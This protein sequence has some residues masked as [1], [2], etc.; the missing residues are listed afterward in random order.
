MCGARDR[1]AARAGCPLDDLERPF[2]SNHCRTLY[3]E[4][5]AICLPPR[6]A[7][8]LH[9]TSPIRHLPPPPHSFALSLALASPTPVPLFLPSS[10]T[11]NCALWSTKVPNNTSKLER[12]SLTPARRRRNYDSKA[13]LSHASRRRAVGMPDGATAHNSPLPLL[14]E[15]EDANPPARH[16]HTAVFLSVGQT[17]SGSQTVNTN[18]SSRDVKDTDEWRVNVVIQGLDLARGTICGSME[19]LDVPKAVSP[20]VT[21]WKGEIIDNRNYFFWTGR[22]D[23]EVEQDV[24]HWKKFVAFAPMH[25]RVT[26][27]RGDDIDLSQSRYIFMRWKE[28]F[29]VSPGED[30]GLTIAGFYYVCMDRQTG[31]ILGYYYDPHSQ[32]YQR[33][34]LNAVSSNAGFSFADYEFN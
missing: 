33:L 16:L 23:A 3:R 11:K 30:C 2:R 32:P 15:E 25:S 18:S 31:A 6:T 27:D 34:Q 20:V 24:D 12:T 17:F 26:R 1:L 7:T 9:C 10:S 8:R 13:F 4:R 22:W 28:I 19:A 5:H 29:F 21:F 14:E